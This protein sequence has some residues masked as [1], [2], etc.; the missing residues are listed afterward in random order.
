MGLLRRKEQV[1]D[2]E[3]SRSLDVDGQPTPGEHGVPHRPDA[4]GSDWRLPVAFLGT[5][6]VFYSA[7]AFALYRLAAFLF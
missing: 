7:I 1:K 3:G 6:L 2:V 4:R 5:M